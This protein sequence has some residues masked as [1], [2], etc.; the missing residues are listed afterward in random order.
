ML[1]VLRRLLHRFLMMDSIA[2]LETRAVYQARL[3][4]NIHIQLSGPMILS[5]C[6]SANVTQQGGSVSD[7][8]AIS[9]IQYNVLGLS[10]D[11]FSG[12]T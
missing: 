5:T 6:K 1:P 11:H 4:S 3:V 10:S 8:Q 7:K 12:R 2:P 9:I